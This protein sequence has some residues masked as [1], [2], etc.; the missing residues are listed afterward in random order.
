[1]SD[2]FANAAAAAAQPTASP[3]ELAV[4][5]DA[6]PAKLPTVLDPVTGEVY[7]ELTDLATD[8]LAELLYHLRAAEADRKLARLA[9]D[10]ELRARMKRENRTDAIVGDYRL[11]VRPTGRREWDAETLR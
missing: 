1:M 10:A 2:P 7:D 5:H 3:S 4:Q 9:V 8:R 6:D 11:V